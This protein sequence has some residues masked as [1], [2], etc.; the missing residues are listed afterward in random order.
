VGEGGLVVLE[1]RAVEGQWK[2]GGILDGA[3]DFGQTREHLAHRDVE[4]A[5]CVE[6]DAECLHAEI[7]LE[8]SQMLVAGRVACREGPTRTRVGV[9]D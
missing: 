3:D 9:V 6:V 2:V 1:R 4:V 7:G 5:C 8:S